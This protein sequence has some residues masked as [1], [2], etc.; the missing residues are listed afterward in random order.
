[1][2]LLITGN[3][4]TVKDEI[5]FKIINIDKLITKKKMFLNTLNKCHQI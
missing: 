2:L 3:T 4:H 1:M 5:V